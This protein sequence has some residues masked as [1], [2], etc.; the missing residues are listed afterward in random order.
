MSTRAE[1]AAVDLIRDHLVAAL[2]RFPA[3]RRFRVA[4]SGGLDST[5]LLHALAAVRDR[6]SADVTALHVD[7]G[8]HPASTS[9]TEHCRAQC[10]AL[11]LDILVS[12]VEVVGADEEGLE[13][14]ARRARYDAFAAA[15][16]PQDCL[17]TAHHRDDQAETVLLQLLRGCGPH[18]LAAMAP[19]DDFA[20]G[21][22]ARPLLDLERDSLLAYAE[23]AGLR[24]I[25]D[26]SNSDTRLRRNF[27]RHDIIPRLQQYWPALSRTL[28]RSAR[29]AAAAAT[30]LDERAAADLAR[31]RGPQPYMLSIAGLAALSRARADNLLR[32]WLHGLSLP[33]PSAAQLERLHR[34]VLPARVD[35]MPLLAWP[36]AEIRRYRGWLYAM[37]P[38]SPLDT[39]GEW[40]WDNP[41]VPLDLPDGSRLLAHARSGAGLS[42]ARIAV[43]GSVTVR[44]RR[45]GE[46]CRPAT[47]NHVRSLKKLL[48]GSGI[49][50][51]LR[52]RMPLLYVGGELAAVAGVFVVEGF[53]ARAGEQGWEIQHLSAALLQVLQPTSSAGL[54]PV[55]QSK[56][57]K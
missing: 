21:Y 22:H 11:R 54:L 39:A 15:M 37:A 49:P 56:S 55:H 7:H 23:A 3:P 1:P 46:R 18:G 50:P 41:S 53:Q 44:F 24:W 43:A 14:A 30:L 16:A 38:L 26:P 28:S 20:A 8:L 19:I 57:T 4:Y 5:V 52:S 25:D 6:L 48:Q 17:L 36:G 9:W 12:R 40:R 42:I 27:L 33:L 51:W 35:A 10:E 13:A 29:H 31:L 47:S 34:D 32:H 45:G 2:G